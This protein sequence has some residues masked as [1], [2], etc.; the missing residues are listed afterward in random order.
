MIALSQIETVFS[1]LD[2]YLKTFSTANVVMADEPGSTP[3]RPNFPFVTYKILTTG[4]DTA[5][6]HGLSSSPVLDDNTKIDVKRNILSNASISV[7]VLSNSFNEAYDLAFKTFRWFGV[8]GYET[9]SSSGIVVKPL[10]KPQDRTSSLGMERETRYGFDLRFDSLE[11]V[12]ERKDTIASLVLSGQSDIT[13]PNTIEYS[14]DGSEIPP[15]PFPAPTMVP[16]PTVWEYT[17]IS[18]KPNGWNW[19]CE[20]FIDDPERSRVILIYRYSSVTYYFEFTY[21]N[22]NAGI[23]SFASLGTASNLYG[24]RFIVDGGYINWMGAVNIGG[25]TAT[26]KIYRAPL[27]DPANIT[28]T[29][30]SLPVGAGGGFDVPLKMSDGRYV[31]DAG[32]YLPGLLVTKGT[33]YFDWEYFDADGGNNYPYET[34]LIEDLT[35]GHL[36]R[37]NGRIGGYGTNAVKEYDLDAKI[38]VKTTENVF[39][40]LNHSQRA[41]RVEET[42]EVYLVGGVPPLSMVYKFNTSD[43]LAWESRYGWQ[44][45]NPGSVPSPLVRFGDKYLW[46]SGVTIYRSGTKEAGT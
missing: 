32:V 44:N 42:G 9:I 43:Y 13:G 11:E 33:D 2:V 30:Y 10:S 39:S 19:N 28:W 4:E 21:A 35:T 31:M 29:G 45:I 46:I 17:T 12:V 23:M 6:L 22:I 5:R 1:A 26:P 18:P 8:E 7:T 36:I 20:L 15:P 14:I 25:L 16:D 41:I 40:G 24:A 27:S 34:G 37:Y 38:L 3:K